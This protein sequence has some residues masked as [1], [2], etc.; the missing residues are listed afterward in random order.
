METIYEVSRRITTGE[1]ITVGKAMELL[2]LDL[3]GIDTALPQSWG[4]R[5]PRANR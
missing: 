1:R 4:G 5:L 3:P 2:G